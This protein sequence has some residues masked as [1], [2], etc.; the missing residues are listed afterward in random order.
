MEDIEIIYIRNVPI[1]PDNIQVI[2]Y[3]IDE[4]LN[5]QILHLLP[6]LWSNRN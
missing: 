2:I 1:N 4:V 5:E 3:E 6:D